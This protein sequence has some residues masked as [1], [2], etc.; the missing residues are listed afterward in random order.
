MPTEAQAEMPLPDAAAR[1]AMFLDIDG[2]LADIA[3]TPQAVAISGHAHDM[4][5]RLVRACD[6]AVALI[7]GRAIAEIDRLFAPLALPVAGLHGLER[8]GADGTVHRNG[9]EGPG[10]AARAALQ[11]FV[12]KNPGTLIED[13]GASLALHYR[14]R[15]E[16]EADAEAL[17]MA[18]A[19]ASPALTVQHGKMV[20]ELRAGGADKGSATRAFMTEAPFRGRMPVFVGDDV[21]DEAG[22]KAVNDL[23]GLSIRVGNGGNSAARYRIASV[24]GVHDWLA[25]VAD[26][27]GGEMA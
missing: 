15:P 21:T 22:F 19:A 24:A 14:G 25:R 12:R 5:G 20:L 6:G 18:L 11:K 3:P 4:L 27:R 13:K 1:W 9:R 7:S 2:T 23:G 26:A 17:V 10:A 16:A 8:R